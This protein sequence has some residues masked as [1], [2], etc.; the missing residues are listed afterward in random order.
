MD[1]TSS[2]ITF[3]NNN[4]WYLILYRNKWNKLKNTKYILDSGT[5]IHVLTNINC[6]ENL[7]LLTISTIQKDE[8]SNRV[9]Y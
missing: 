9:Q 2:D 8:Q 6:I 7:T 5:S 4:V 3:N 1:V